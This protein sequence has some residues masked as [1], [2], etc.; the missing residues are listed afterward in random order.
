MLFRAPAFEPERLQIFLKFKRSPFV[1][2]VSKHCFCVLL[3]DEGRAVL[4]HAQH[5]LC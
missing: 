3:H 2:S 1:L 5:E 4:R